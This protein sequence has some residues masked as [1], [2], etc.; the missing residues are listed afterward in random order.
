MFPT[1]EM[2][3]FCVLLFPTPLSSQ[4]PQAPGK[5][6]VASTPP[7]AKIKIDGQSMNQPTDFTFVVSPGEHS[8]AVTTLAKC[9]KPIQAP[10]KSGL[11]TSIHCDAE[12]GGVSRL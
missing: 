12:R 4:T 1:F 8:V 3:F 5:L 9:A 2:A 11:V 6:L 10:V 7:G